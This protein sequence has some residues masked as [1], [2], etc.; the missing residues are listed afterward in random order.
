[1]LDIK[2]IREN[3]DAIRKDLEKRGDTEK[4]SWVDEIISKDCEY[5]KGLQTVQDL[6]A[7]RNSVSKDINQAKKEGKDVK[8]ILEEAKKIPDKIK[9]IEDNIEKIAKDI[10]EKRMRLPNILHE[11]VPIGDDEE[12][13]VVLREVGKKR[14]FDFESL[15]FGWGFLLR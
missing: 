4:I 14:K 6:R 3:P 15:V 10:K 7:K 12:G 2:F 5:R 1:M 9:K 8:A 11:T 13:N